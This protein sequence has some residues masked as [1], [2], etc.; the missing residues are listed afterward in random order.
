[1][2]TIAPHDA[3]KS[4]VAAWFAQLRDRICGEFEAIED[5]AGPN[6]GRFERTSWDRPDG[7]GGVMSV[8]K[9]QVFE[10]AGVNISVVQGNF[11]PD[12]A[13]RIPGTEAGAAFWASRSRAKICSP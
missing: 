4:D 12:F 9:G 6:P 11:T 3:L 10:K 2:S 8:I 5:M 13:A 1:M 7:G